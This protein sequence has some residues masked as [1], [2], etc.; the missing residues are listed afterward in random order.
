MRDQ[1][2][3]QQM[4]G[5]PPS[6]AAPA[7]HQQDEIYLKIWELEQQQPGFDVA[8]KKLT[9]GIERRDATQLAFFDL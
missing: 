5:R 9:D 2:Y 8:L 1:D 3:L 6:T 4:L 7:T